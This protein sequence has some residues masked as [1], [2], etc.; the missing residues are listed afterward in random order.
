MCIPDRSASLKKSDAQSLS[1]PP[2]IPE[3]S[4]PLSPEPE[5]PPNMF[6][7]S[8]GVYSPQPNAYSPQPRGTYSATRDTFKNASGQ[9]SGPLPPGPVPPESLDVQPP[10]SAAPADES[11]TKDPESASAQASGSH[12]PTYADA[13]S[14]QTPWPASGYRRT[15]ALST[16]SQQTM[17][18]GKLSVSIDFGE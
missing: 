6:N 13:A 1:P 16:M 17:N 14:G 4:P 5:V 8:L 2:P 15:G 9:N 18:E 3:G 11:P 7:A 12:R 10:N